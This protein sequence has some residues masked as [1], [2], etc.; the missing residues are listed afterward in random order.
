MFIKRSFD[1]VLSL[2]LIAILIL[3]IICIAFVIKIDSD[4]PSFFFS[5]RFG[6]NNK[7][8]L[9][10]KFRTMVTNA[11]QLPTHLLKDSKK[12]ITKIGILLRKTSLDETPQLWSILKGDM[13]FVGPR[14]ALFNQNDLITLREKFDI[15]LLTPG[16]TGWAQVNGR[17]E[18]S[19]NKKVKLEN[20]YKK[21]QSI[22]LDLK[23][24]YLTFQKVVRMKH[25]RL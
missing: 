13:S 9:M 17:D 25:V 22:T 3:P 7:L 15:H 2:I 20:F 4:G 12:Y 10:P 8:F 5:Q 18:I 24:L 6:K 16:L 21:H 1:I 14:P 23:I 19:I 11:P